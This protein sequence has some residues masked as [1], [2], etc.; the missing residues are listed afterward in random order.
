MILSGD[1]VKPKEVELQYA[2]NSVASNQI[3]SSE[4][5]SQIGVFYPGQWNVESGPDFLNARL[6][7]DGKNIVGDI[8]IHTYPGDWFVHGHTFDPK[9]KN[10]VLHVVRHGYRSISAEKK[11]PDIPLLIFSDEIIK[12]LLGTKGSFRKYHPGLCAAKLNNRSIDSLSEYFSCIGQRR[13]QNKMVS[14]LSEIISIGAE[15]SLMKHLF[16][17][18]GYKNNRNEFLELYQ[19]FSFYG[20]TLSFFE[21]EAVLWGE[22]GF[23]SQ[24]NLANPHECINKYVNNLWHEW[25]KLRKEHSSSGINW[26]LGNVRFSNSPWRRVAGLV[27]FL[28]LSSFNPL[29]TLLDLFEKPLKDDELLKEIIKLFTISDDLLGSYLSFTSKL[30]RKSVLIGKA[31]GIDI[32]GNI[33]LPFML[34]YGKLNNSNLIQQKAVNLW[35]S[36]PISQSNISLKISAQRWMIKEKDI[37]KIFKTFSALQGAIYLYKNFCSFLGMDCSKCPE[38]LH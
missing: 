24:T 32:I 35:V 30:T 9:Y 14:F 33:V 18:C 36:L 5:E 3:F 10:V 1:G 7:I 19:R 28:K 27:T 2:W 38:S 23:L 16:E 26:N 4:N 22:S 15:A 31:R 25:W 6:T 34:A 17:A 12:S 20:S 37:Q 11:I 8:E 29:K 13:L 21:K